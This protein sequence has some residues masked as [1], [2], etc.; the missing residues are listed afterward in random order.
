MQ[1]REMDN[2]FYEACNTT[3]LLSLEKYGQDGSD[4][5]ALPEDARTLL[6][7]KDTLLNAVQVRLVS[8]VLP[9]PPPPPPPQRPSRHLYASCYSNPSCWLQSTRPCKLHWV[10][11]PD[12]ADVCLHLCCRC[13]HNQL[14]ADS[15]G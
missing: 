12:L 2:R 7:D 4:L 1:V 14:L 13:N 3:A 6:Q 5:D 8:P 11:V 9:P 10:P 15:H